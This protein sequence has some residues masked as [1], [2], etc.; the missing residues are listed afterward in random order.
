MGCGPKKINQL[1]SL[2]FLPS[3]VRY[4][5]VAHVAACQLINRPEELMH[6][7]GVPFK[8][9]LCLKNPKGDHQLGGAPIPF[10]WPPWSAWSSLASTSPA[11]QPESS[12]RRIHKSLG[13]I[14]KA[15]GDW[16][17]KCPGMK[18]ALGQRKVVFQ[19]SVSFHP[20][21]GL[22][23]VRAESGNCTPKAP[24]LVSHCLQPPTLA[25]LSQETSLTDKSCSA[26]LPDRSELLGSDTCI[27]C[28]T[29]RH[30][31]SRPEVVC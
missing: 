22:T 31:T 1:V 15:G 30:Y 9:F 29:A 21:G 16:E 20:D 28:S 5:T 18:I 17:V 26:M 13:P 27:N 8:A 12:A 14:R 24:L 7:T 11:L 4:L 25:F 23:L 3:F 19:H 6:A 2:P 10:T